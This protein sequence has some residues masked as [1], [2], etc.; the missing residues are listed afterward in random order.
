MSLS[1]FIPYASYIPSMSSEDYALFKALKEL[2]KLLNSSI[3]IADRASELAEE[4]S[5]E[6]DQEISTD[7]EN[8]Q[9][10]LK[11]LLDDLDSVFDEARTLWDDEE[12][13]EK[14]LRAGLDDEENYKTDSERIQEEIDEDEDKA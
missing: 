14:S 4:L 3:D 6:F 9:L 5:G 13:M 2:Q 11:N 7:M 8:I 10:K 12:A 1:T